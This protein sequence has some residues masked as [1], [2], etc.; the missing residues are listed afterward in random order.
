MKL[1]KKFRLFRYIL[2]Q[3]GYEEFEV[4]REEFNNKEQGVSA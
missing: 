3:F 1:S 2:R 4:L